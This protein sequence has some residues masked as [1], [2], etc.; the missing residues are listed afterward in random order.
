M[1]QL[2][3]GPVIIQCGH[4]KGRVGLYDDDYSE[5]SAIVYLWKEPGFVIIPAKYLTNFDG[6]DVF[7]NTMGYS[8][9]AHARAKKIKLDQRLKD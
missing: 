3:Y 6:A 9:I 4:Y 1:S 8:V 7:A 2:K 5:K